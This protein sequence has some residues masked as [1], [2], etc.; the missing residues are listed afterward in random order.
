MQT[1]EMCSYYICRKKI[2]NN[3]T[4]I[5]IYKS[6]IFPLKH[7]YWRKAWKKRTQDTF[8]KCETHTYTKKQNKKKHA[9]IQLSIALTTR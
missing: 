7:K 1:K 9:W 5:H 4:S 6:F 3:Y 2:K 8:R